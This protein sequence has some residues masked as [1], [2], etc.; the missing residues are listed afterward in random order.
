MTEHECI[1]TGDEC[2]NCNDCFYTGLMFDRM[3]YYR[4]VRE[5]VKE[6]NKRINGDYADD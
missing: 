5:E 4:K 3:S 1:I 2:N 6:I